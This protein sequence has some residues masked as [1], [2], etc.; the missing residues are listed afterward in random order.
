MHLTRLQPTELENKRPRQDMTEEHMANE[1][2]H[3]PHA[4]TENENDWMSGSRHQNQT[5]G[6]YSS[7]KAVY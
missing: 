7:H 6:F 1:H 5:K 2:Q 4:L 3:K